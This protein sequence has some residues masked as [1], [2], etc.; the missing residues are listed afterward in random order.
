MTLC[1]CRGRALR[2]F[3]DVP[4]FLEVVRLVQQEQVQWIDEQI[5][6][7][8][9]PQITEEIVAVLAGMVMDLCHLTACRSHQTQ[10]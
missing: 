1:G 5:V 8:P 3:V 10:F 2:P 9:L 4:P 6:E 7:L